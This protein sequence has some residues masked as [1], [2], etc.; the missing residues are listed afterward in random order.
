MN[1]PSASPSAARRMG[2]DCVD[3]ER[4]ANHLVHHPDERDGVRF[5]PGLSL[6]QGRDD[7]H[8]DGADGGKETTE[9]AHRR[10]H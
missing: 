3:E 4:P 6:S 7:R 2:S 8:A 9:N 10:G 5:E 1:G